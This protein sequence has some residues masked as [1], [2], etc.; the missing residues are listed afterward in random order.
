MLNPIEHIQPRHP[1]HGIRGHPH[2]HRLQP[3]GQ[4]EYIGIR[5]EMTRALRAEEKP[6]VVPEKTPAQ[7]DLPNQNE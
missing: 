3:R 4:L 2:Q 5:K 1:P 7:I 6:I